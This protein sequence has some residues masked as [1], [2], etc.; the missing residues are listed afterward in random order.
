MRYAVQQPDAVPDEQAAIK[1]FSRRNFG[2]KERASLNV[3]ATR[4]QLFYFR[5]ALVIRLDSLRLTA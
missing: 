5:T 1:L 2:I 3:T 4:K